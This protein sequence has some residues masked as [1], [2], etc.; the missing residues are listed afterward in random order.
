[1][2]ASASNQMRTDANGEK[3]TAFKPDSG[4]CPT[5][6]LSFCHVTKYS[7]GDKRENNSEQQRGRV[8]SI[9]DAFIM[10]SL[11]YMI[12]CSITLP[13][14]KLQARVDVLSVQ[15]ALIFCEPMLGQ[16]AKQSR[17]ARS[18]HHRIQPACNETD[19]QDEEHIHQQL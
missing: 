6:T 9:D 1:M 5:S 12:L 3:K 19:K 8:H 7:T 17:R 18:L 2:S 16:S 10:S 13:I 15:D 14:S 11:D 4:C